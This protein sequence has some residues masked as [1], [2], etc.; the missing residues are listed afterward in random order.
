VTDPRAVKEAV[1][2]G[3]DH[4]LQKKGSFVLD[5]RTAQ[6]PPPPPST[7][8]AGTVQAARE[9]RRTRYMA[10]YAAQPPIDIYHHRDVEAKGRTVAAMAVPF[11]SDVPTL[12]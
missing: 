7:A 3:V 4:V 9:A 8:D 6:A 1:R 2:T 12:F 5:L 10:R 11:P